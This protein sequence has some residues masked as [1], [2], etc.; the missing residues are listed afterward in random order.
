MD[1]SM[2]YDSGINQWCHDD[3]LTYGEDVGFRCTYG[4][5]IMELDAFACSLIHNTW[6]RDEPD[7]TETDIRC[8][9][10]N[11]GR[12][13]TVTRQAAFLG[14]MGVVIGNAESKQTAYRTKDR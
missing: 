12:V 11:A 13:D 1:T 7:L 6:I 3:P 5:N 14:K 2:V 9:K 10:Q 8:G 4:D